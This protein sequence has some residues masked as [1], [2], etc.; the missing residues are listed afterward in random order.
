MYVYI[1]DGDI[2]GHLNLWEYESI[3]SSWHGFI[4]LKIKKITELK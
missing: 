1:A 3:N 2:K 4:R